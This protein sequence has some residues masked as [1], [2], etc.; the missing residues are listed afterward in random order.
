MEETKLKVGN[1]VRHNSSKNAPEMVV[2]QI[3]TE[4]NTIGNIHCRYWHNDQFHAKPFL[5]EELIKLID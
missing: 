5:Q 4:L 2:I 3:K 1:R